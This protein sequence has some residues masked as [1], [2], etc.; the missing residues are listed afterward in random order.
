MTVQTRPDHM[1]A[2]LLIVGGGIN[3]ACIARDAAGRG[4]KVVLC[5]Q[6]DL[7]QATSSS[8]SKL[9]HGGLRYLE[10]YEFRLVREALAEREVLLKAAPHIIWPLRFVLPH[11]KLLRPRWMIRLGLFLYDHIGG[12]RSLPGTKS[13]DLT[14]S[15]QGQPL[16]PALTRGF[17]YSDC[18]VEDSR[19]V[20]LNAKDAEQR[21]AEI[22]V[23]TR[24]IDARR[25]DGHWVATLSD[26]VTGTQRSVKAR[27]LVNAAGPWVDRFLRHGLG[28]N[29]EA[30]L[31]LVKGS[32]IIV[33]KLYEGAHAYILQNTDKRVIFTI[34][35]ERNFT[36]I[37]T[38]DL[39]YQG[40]PA[41]VAIS[42]EEVTYLCE[43]VSA[44]FENGPS[45]D[46]IVRTYAGVRPLYDDHSENPSAVTR[47]YVFDV[48][49]PEG[50]AA[51]LSIYGGKI[52]TSRK[53]AEHAM[54][55]LKP[56]LSDLKPTWT[57]GQTLPGGDIANADFDAF[58]A[59]L[60]SQYS[61][62]PD[63]LA[64]RYARLYGTL[65]D[66]ILNGKTS[67]EDL[68]GMLGAD[69]YEAEAQYLIKHEWAQ[70]ADDVLWR[71]TK[72]GLVMSQE[73]I[74]RVETWFENRSNAAPVTAEAV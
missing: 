46:Q 7:A 29:E 63:G 34:P 10:M 60:K 27:V 37:G 43:A 4:L 74:Q 15:L 18:W 66:H 49:A 1:E 33:P 8:S 3:G 26:Q 13:L 62:L 35:Y 40:D 71:R 70:T 2:D 30:H 9:I 72:L 32:H 55:K 16:K 57:A 12:R 23:R 59:N 28:R 19:L 73:E 54:E 47:D 48:E 53:L 58:L 31:K 25:E 21:G 41:E 17:E 14:S 67:L 6:A 24:C 45:P 68:G 69:L 51:L 50:G 56:Y 38:T 5:E 44:Y 11:N 22:F 39:V 64:W 36:L 20:V 42:D 65:S 61:F 52:T